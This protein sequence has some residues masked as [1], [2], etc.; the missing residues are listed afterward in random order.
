MVEDD[1]VCRSKAFSIDPH[2]R[3]HGDN[4]A[5]AMRHNIYSIFFSTRVTSNINN[6][7]RQTACCISLIDSMGV[8]INRVAPVAIPKR[9]SAGIEFAHYFQ[10]FTHRTWAKHIGNVG[11]GVGKSAAIF[12]ICTV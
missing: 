10:N 2:I 1:T 5:L 3:Q 12:C 4:S 7:I 11:S 6:Q 9:P 8:L